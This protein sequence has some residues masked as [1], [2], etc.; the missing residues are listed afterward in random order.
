MNIISVNSI[1]PLFIIS[2]I[3]ADYELTSVLPTWHTKYYSTCEWRN[4]LSITHCTC[5]TGKCQQ[6]LLSTS[7]HIFLITF[8]ILL[9]LWLFT[10]N[11]PFCFTVSF[12]NMAINLLQSHLKLLL[13]K[14]IYFF[15]F[16]LDQR[17]FQNSVW[18]IF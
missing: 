14:P 4:Q 2:F 16:K 1:I 7:M 9:L 18:Q 15:S 3:I 12:F 13:Q 17:T 5:V 11:I 8:K 10:I 6:L